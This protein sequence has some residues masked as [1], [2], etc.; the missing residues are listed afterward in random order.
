MYKCVDCG[1]KFDTPSV[2]YETHGL[3][4]PPYEAW[5]T[6]PRCGGDFEEYTPD[7][8]A[9]FKQTIRDEHCSFIKGQYYPIT[10]DGDGIYH[11]GHQNGHKVGISKVFEGSLFTIEEVDLDDPQ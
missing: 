4:C 2:R 11:L 9:V 5:S 3:D 8:V 6:C 10:Y 1:H 7:R